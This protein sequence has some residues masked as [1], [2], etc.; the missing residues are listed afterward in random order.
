[1]DDAMSVHVFEYLGIGVNWGNRMTDLDL[2][3]SLNES[4]RCSFIGYDWN[5]L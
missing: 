3:Y 4:Y 1:M 5:S 2:E